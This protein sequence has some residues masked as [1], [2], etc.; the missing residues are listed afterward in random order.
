MPIN[1]AAKAAMFAAQ[2]DKTFLTLLTLTHPAAGNPPAPVTLRF[3][4]NTEDVDQT[5]PTVTFK[6]FPFQIIFPA[7]QADVLE[8][9]TLVID[10]VDR[11]ITTIIRNL[12]TPPSIKLEVVLADDPDTVQFGPLNFT[13]RVA[14]WDASIIQGELRY[15]ELLAEPYPGDSVAPSTF[16]GVF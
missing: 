14:E 7:S 16:P 10:N 1:L 13:W 6:A 9:A 3:V 15:E 5:G 12:P 2:T 11:G 8:V 4:N